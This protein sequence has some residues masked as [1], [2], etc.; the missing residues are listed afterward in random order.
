VESRGREDNA[1]GRGLKEPTR[2]EGPKNIYVGWS[3]GKVREIWLR[4]GRK[5]V[6][7]KKN[8]KSSL[9]TAQGGKEGARREEREGLGSGGEASL[10]HIFRGEELRS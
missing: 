8:V 3:R 4:A 10:T 7:R 6:R 5:S 9:E 1:R 2:G